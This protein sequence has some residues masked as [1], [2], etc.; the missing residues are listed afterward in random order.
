MKG[1]VSVGHAVIVVN[2][3]IGVAQAEVG[4]ESVDIGQAVVVVASV[5]VA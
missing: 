1:S 4:V 2:G 3:S 5:G